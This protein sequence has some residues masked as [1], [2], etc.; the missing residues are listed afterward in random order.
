MNNNYSSQQQEDGN[1]PNHLPPTNGNG[2][3]RPSGLLSNY[4]QQSQMP[5]PQAWTTPQGPS[6]MS[7]MPNSP[8]FLQ[9]QQPQQYPQEQQA[10]QVPQAPQ[11]PQAWRTPSVFANAVNSVR[12]WSGKMVAARANYVEPNPLEIYH[13]QAIAPVKQTPPWRRS[14]AL[15][16]STRMRHRRARWQKSR[17]NTK[18]ILTITLSVFA[19][20]L[21]IM[22]S[23]GFG[24]AYAY[25]Q[26]QLPRVQS[27]ANQ[28]TEQSTRIYDRNNKLI[29]TAY[30]GK[31][32]RATPVTY[33]YIPGIMQD[34]MI[35]AEDHSFWN[36]SG[37]D[38]QGILRAASQ[39]LSNGG[40]VD[41]GGSTITQQV[42]KNLTGDTQVSLQRK[43][44]EAALAIGLTQQ[45]PKWKVLEMYF[46]VAPFGA[47]ELGVDAAAE[48]YFG[49][50]PKCDSNF[51]CIPAIAY[52]DRDITSCT[53]PGDITTCKI[54]PLLGL[55]RASLLAGMPQNPPAYDPTLGKY[56]ISAAQ[57]RQDYVLNQMLGL[58]MNINLGLGDQTDFSSL[59]PIT[60][61]I[62][63]QVE[64]LTRNIR[65]VGFHYTNID[66]HFV[67]WIV[68]IIE[69]ALGN[70]DGQLGTHLFLTGG[71]N[72]QT[73]IDSNLE[74]FIENDV[75]YQLRSSI[76]QIFVGDYGP[77]NTVHNVND[78]AVVVEDAK[79]GEILAMDG[80]T[81][82]NSTDPTIAGNVNSA[83]ALRSPGSS[84]KPILYSTAF[85]M[86]WYPGI[87]LPDK[88]T[89]FPGGSQSLAVNQPGATYHPFDYGQT[90]H[91]MNSNILLSVANSFN[92]PAV[93]T[94]EFAGLNNVL[95][96]ARR[97]GITDL[98]TD[99]VLYSQA[100]DKQYNT[101]VQFTTQQILGPSLAL[102]AYGISL[103]QM[104]S[105]YQVLADQGM[106]VA[107]Q[108][109]LNIWDNYGHEI[110]HYDPNKAPATRVISQQ[111][112]FLMSSILSNNAARAIEFS[113][114]TVLTTQDWDNRPVAAK[115]GTTDG[116]QDN[117]TIGYTPDIVVGVWS[118]NANG[119]LMKGVVGITGAAPI[120]HDAL[121]YAS[122]KCFSKSEFPGNWTTCGDIKY[123]ADAFNPP[124][125][126][127]QQEVNTVNGLMGNGYL[128]W[129]I[130]SDVP[131]VTGLNTTTNANGNAT[132]TATP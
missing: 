17:P 43:L 6:P 8:V 52:L 127:I 102:G 30:D 126:V 75:R 93:K 31:Y 46:N 98:D 132:P 55:A 32:G 131:T 35:A 24:A 1:N 124:P 44:P 5:Q 21:V 63:N 85:Q 80:S 47:Q 122:G 128:S 41:G 69:N 65:Y 72:I 37:I 48:D 25:Y 129:M 81:D 111:I 34:A 59:G 86:G 67:N 114:D 96:M 91:N 12:Q 54:N 110:Y 60:P 36:N 83:T 77:L 130:D 9:P 119:A 61:A 82:Y 19:V 53:K 95:N 103:L 7:P 64:A 105:A 78:S 58:N 116:Y 39:Y 99:A 113:P 120:W 57:I 15:R 18:K 56:N 10:P 62:I 50:Y 42:I 16:V 104:V 108:Y 11:A 100:Y 97:F 74:S 22:L 40:V 79:T 88:E 26:T 71:F 94:I 76:Y 107:P 49:L 115:T 38:P 123:N 51:N 121:E 23:S 3:A 20:L 29:Y 84:F 68:P 125:G 112:A 89:Y 28:Q 109:V 70:G 92:V 33:N 117:W 106:R 118:G 14:R 2:A 87:V 101:N 90:Y 4:A 45:Y 13:P 27:L 73:T 66:P